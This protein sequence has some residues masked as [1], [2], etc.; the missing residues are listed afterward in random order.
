MY[1]LEDMQILPIR[2]HIVQRTNQ[3]KAKKIFGKKVLAKRE[4][5]AVL[6]KS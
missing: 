6:A 3:A 1:P 5:I 2:R 4:R